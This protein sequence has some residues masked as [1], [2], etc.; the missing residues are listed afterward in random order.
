MVS[1]A[2][3]GRDWRLFAV[4]CVI[5]IGFL[6]LAIARPD[7]MKGAL[8]GGDVPVGGTNVAV[9][10]GFFLIISA[11]LLALVYMALAR[12]PRA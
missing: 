11:F 9:I 12:P 10:Y 8:G 1:P 7:I 2:I 3:R 5:Y 4:Y 6:W